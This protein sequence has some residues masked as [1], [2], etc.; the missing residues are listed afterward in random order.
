[1]SSVSVSDLPPALR[2]SSPDLR[3]K[4]I[5]A[6]IAALGIGSAQA[7]DDASFGNNAIAARW[8]YADGKL[9]SVVVDDKL[10]QRALEITAPFV[11]TLADGSKLATADMRAAAAPKTAAL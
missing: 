4:W 11:L 8:S 10:N 9:A 5:A 6:L 7:A 1:M 2:R 3:R